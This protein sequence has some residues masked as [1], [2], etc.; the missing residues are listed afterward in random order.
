MVSYTGSGQMTFPYVASLGNR[1]RSCWPTYTVEI[2]DTTHHHEP[3]PARRFA[4]GSTGLRHS[5]THRAGEVLRGLPIPRQADSLASSGP[6]DHP[7]LVAVRGLGAGYL[8][9]VPSSAWGLPLPL[10]CH[11]QVYQVGR[12]RSHPHHP[13]WLRGQVH[14]GSR[15]PFPGPQ[16]HHH[17]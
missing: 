3:S 12:G 5:T 10:R 6:A 14:L 11:R 2:A 9:P 8:G 1:G 13:S 7:A 17:R 16:P 4:V 15:E